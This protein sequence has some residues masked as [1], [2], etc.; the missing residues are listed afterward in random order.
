MMARERAFAHRRAGRDVG[1]EPVPVLA[2]PR[3]SLA[4][5]RDA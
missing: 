4:L 1:L 3:A 2:G 5:S